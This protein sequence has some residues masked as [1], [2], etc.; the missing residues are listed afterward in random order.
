M[1]RL[2]A[3]AAAAIVLAACGEDDDDATGGTTATVPS[4]SETPPS[5]S[6]PQESTP[7]IE[8]PTTPPSTPPTSAKPLPR[9][10]RRLVPIPSGTPID[11]TMP[12]VEDAVADLARR[13]DVEPSDVT[14]V[15]ALAVT[16]PDGSMG[17]PEPGM[18]YT[19]VLVDG[20]FVL[21]EAGGRQYRY[22]GGSP[23][24]LCEQGKPAN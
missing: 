7:S 5:S 22:H 11:S 9:V 17:C 3:I 13:L 12:L 1:R 18:A 20:T 2:L 19:Q 21:L 14:I 10:S 6:T 23:L 15:E 24:F 4:V 16:W 8:P